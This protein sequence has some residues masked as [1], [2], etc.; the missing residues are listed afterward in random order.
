[1][2][3]FSRIMTVPKKENEAQVEYHEPVFYQATESF[4]FTEIVH[5]VAYFYEQKPDQLQAII[6]FE[7]SFYFN[8]I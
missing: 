6:E 2:G 8:K 7:K 4:L 5:E 3:C 1:M